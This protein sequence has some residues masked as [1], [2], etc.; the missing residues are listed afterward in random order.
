M[1]QVVVLV[2][3][4]SI[5]IAIARRV[6]VGKHLVLADYSVDHAAA[7]KTLLENAGFE[8]STIQCDLGSKESIL[9]LVKYAQS[10]RVCHNSGTSSFCNML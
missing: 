4:G 2:G 6:S 8:C 10:K 3:A 5:G 9:K 7:A 1:K